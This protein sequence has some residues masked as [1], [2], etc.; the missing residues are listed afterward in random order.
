MSV[1]G[2]DG[3]L[4]ELVRILVDNAFKYSPRGELV[5][6]SVGNGESPVLTVR[7]HG[8][9]LSEEDRARAFDRFFRG[10]AAHDVE[11]SGLGLAIARAICERHGATLDLEP[12]PGGGIAASVRFPSGRSR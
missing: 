1:V 3:R 12:A 4:R 7:D 9:G 5:E 11:G 2:D 10:S 8:P 6:V